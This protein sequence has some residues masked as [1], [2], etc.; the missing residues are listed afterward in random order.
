MGGEIKTN[1]TDN[2]KALELEMDLRQKGMEKMQESM[3]GYMKSVSKRTELERKEKALPIA[4]MGT[5][6]V[7]HGE[8]FEHDSEFGAC[9][10]CEL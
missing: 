1:V 5:S 7:S 9:L 3:A 6:M 2:F 10:T 8:D 4:Y